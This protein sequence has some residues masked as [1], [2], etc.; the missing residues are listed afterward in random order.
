[1]LNFVVVQANRN[2][3]LASR[4]CCSETHP[5]IDS[6]AETLSLHDV[7]LERVCGVQTRASSAEEKWRSVIENPGLW[8]NN[9]TTKRNP[10]APDFKLKSDPSGAVVLWISSR[11]T[12]DWAREKLESSGISAGYQPSGFSDMN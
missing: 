10:K 12:P 1:M 9:V 3:L 5:Q 4:N 11:D 7:S 2:E 8:W 6:A